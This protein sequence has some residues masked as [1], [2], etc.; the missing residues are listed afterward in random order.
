MANNVSI[1]LRGHIYLERGH[2]TK[3]YNTNTPPI[4]TC[5][6]SINYIIV[7]T[8]D[9]LSGYAILRCQTDTY[10]EKPATGQNS[11]HDKDSALTL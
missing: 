10:V 4:S 8:K 9:S 7:V 5:K 6:E 3:N 2:Y 11:N 1:H